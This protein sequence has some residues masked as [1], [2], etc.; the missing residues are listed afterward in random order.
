MVTD[1]VYLSSIVEKANLCN[2]KW[3]QFIDSGG[4]LQYH[5]I[6]PL[7][8]H[9]TLITIF[10]INLSEELSH[11]PTLEYYGTDGTPVGKL[12]SV[13]S[14][15][16]I[17]QHCLGAI[18]SQAQIIIVGTH[19][20]VAHVCSESIENKNHQLEAL[21]IYGSFN[22][23]YKGEK[24]KKVIF[25]VNGKAP[26]DED[27]CVAQFIRQEIAAMSPQPIK[28]PIAWF[29]LEVFLRRSSYDGILSLDE[30]QLHALR[31]H[32]EKDAFSA[33]LYHL[34]HHSVFLYYP[35]VLP[36]TVFCDP[37]VVLTKVSELVQCLHKLNSD[38]QVGAVA[39]R[40]H[41]EMF[42]CH[43]LL[44]VKL[45]EKFPE[46]YNEVL[47]TPQDLLKI[48]ESVHAI[49][50]IRDGE[51]LMP[52]L[53]PHLDSSKVCKYLQRSK[54]LII[55]PTN[56]FIPSG[57]FCCLV[58]N[59]LSLNTTFRWKVCMEKENP[60]C[61]YRNCI[62]FILKDGI[63]VVTLVDMFSYIHI[64][65]I[66]ACAFSDHVYRE[67]RDCIHSGIMSACR[68]LKCSVQF[69]DAFMCA[70]P[71]CNSESPHLAVVV[72]LKSSSP[73]YKWRCTIFEDQNGDLTE[74]QL[75]W[76]READ[77]TKHNCCPSGTVEL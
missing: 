5:D 68:A 65:V 71:R 54:Y 63:E 13:L 56:G 43:G 42:R 77:V 60:L 26:Q 32:I 11:H 35:E 49:A 34:V 74:D 3:I 61:L 19:R 51:Y 25:A 38:K 22:V 64:S 45:L 1:I 2:V 23:L 69:Q 67:I 21:L 58:A 29:Q 31:L 44:S 46:H 18:N 36:Q 57:L 4:Q 15:K 39:G 72:H 6:F 30:C 24:P 17:L 55:K 37:Q 12:Q 10:V 62:S 50:K 52:A 59:L 73:V 41:L 9:N 40:S 53:L 66:G 33:A 47:F 70:G 8:I 75:M 76:L 27:R 48:L 28:M 20:D 16:Q 14:H 7:F